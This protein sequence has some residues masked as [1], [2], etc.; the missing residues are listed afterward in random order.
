[1]LTLPEEGRNTFAAN[2]KPINMKRIT[3]ILLTFGL[4]LPMLVLSTVTKAQNQFDALK[5]EQDTLKENVSTL[6][7][8]VGGV[9]ERIANAEADL[10]K[11]TKIKLSGYV[12]AQ[13]QHFEAT[14]TYPNN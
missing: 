13:W 14:N 12:Q 5:K 2:Y 8:K 9:E 10:S 6:R 1:M 3:N 4:I 11:L 7:D